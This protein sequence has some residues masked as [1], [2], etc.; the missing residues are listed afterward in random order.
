VPT[1]PTETDQ[2]LRR[3]TEISEACNATA[4][5]A[6]TTDMHLHGNAL[7]QF[8]DSQV[9]QIGLEMQND[10]LCLTRDD[11][12]LSRSR[13]VKLYADTY[14]FAHSDYFTFDA[15]GMIRRVNLTDPGPPEHRQEVQDRQKRHW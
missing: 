7:R 3:R 8:Y 4:G 14:D 10:A 11:L 1:T 12:E 15:R 9:R 13:Y 2:K 5:R 6:T